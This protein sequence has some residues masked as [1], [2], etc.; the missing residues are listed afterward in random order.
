MDLRQPG[1]HD[2]TDQQV[3]AFE[4][5]ITK[6]P[7]QIVAQQPVLPVDQ[8]IWFRCGLQVVA[9]ARYGMP[10]TAARI[11]HI[12]A[13]ARDDVDM[14]VPDGLPGG[15][16]SVEADVIAVGPQ[17]DVE[18]ALDLIDKGQDVGPLIVTSFRLGSDR[19]SRHDEGMS[20]ANR[21]AIGDDERMIVRREPLRR[22][23]RQER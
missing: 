6:A 15:R 1:F 11:R 4:P 7:Q 8:C 20:W 16:A 5:R 2:E 18:L 14:K 19:A 13:V 17:L 22:W 9:L 23:H 3:N 12:A 21:E 10:H